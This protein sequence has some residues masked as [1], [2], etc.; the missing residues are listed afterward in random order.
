[1]RNIAKY[2][3]YILSLLVI[4]C[5]SMSGCFFI[6]N[7]I[8]Y[9]LQFLLVTEALKDGL[10]ASILRV[11]YYT[12]FYIILF[13]FLTKQLSNNRVLNIA[14]INCGLYIFISLLYV[15]LMPFTI[16][17]FFRSFF[18]YFVISTFA[19]PFILSTIPFYKKLVNSFERPKSAYVDGAYIPSEDLSSKEKSVNT[20]FV[21]KYVIFTLSLFVVEVFIFTAESMFFVHKHRLHPE[22]MWDMVLFCL[23]FSATKFIFYFL[24]QIVPFICF[25][26]KIDG[27]RRVLKI[28][29]LNGC[30]YI[31]ISILYAFVLKPD[32]KIYFS[33]GF[34]YIFILAT[35]ISPFVLDRIPYYRKLSMELQKPNAPNM[36]KLILN[37]IMNPA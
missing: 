18:Y 33:Q 36:F 2:F 22:Y 23:H 31:L 3:I 35:F 16:E 17:F 8:Q 34:F 28:A 15:V 6:E 29:A 1:M 26:S 19:S 4:E 11:V 20:A 25:M 5:I 32:T 14:F 10:D 7:L 12:P 21:L 13:V 9:K 24:L 30:L 27:E 37:A